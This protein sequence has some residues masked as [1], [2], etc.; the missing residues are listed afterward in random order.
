MT[1]EQ[2]LQAILTAPADTLAALDAVLSGRP[3]AGD[4][5]GPPCYR[6]FTMTDTGKALG[7]CRATVWRLVNAGA[8]PTVEIRPGCR[9]VPEAAIAKFAREGLRSGGGA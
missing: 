7:V 6:L 5:K 1:T 8:L 9:R 2:R 4:D 3:A